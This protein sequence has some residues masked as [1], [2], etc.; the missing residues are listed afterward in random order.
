[1]NL[2]TVR[3]NCTEKDYILNYRQ[4]KAFKKLL[5]DLVED[6]L[7]VTDRA[8]GKLTIHFFLPKF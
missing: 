8:P 4:S 5:N 1:M 7:E 2:K 3:F 6:G